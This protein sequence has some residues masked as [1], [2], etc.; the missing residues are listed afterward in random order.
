[1]KMAF[2]FKNQFMSTI[3]YTFDM[4]MSCE[5]ICRFIYFVIKEPIEGCCVSF[6]RKPQ[7]PQRRWSSFFNKLYLELTVIV[8]F[9]FIS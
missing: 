1:M 6:L 3:S 7:Q 4:S 9:H 5:G 8:L 2:Q